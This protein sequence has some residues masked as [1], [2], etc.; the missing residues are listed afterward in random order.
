MYV[1][2]K[3]G[4]LFCIELRTRI[5]TENSIFRYPIKYVQNRI[6]YA[7]MLCIFSLN[8]LWDLK[9]WAIHYYYPF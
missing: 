8:L 9:N 3:D 4:S 1:S 5:E 7:Y 6:T 2:Y